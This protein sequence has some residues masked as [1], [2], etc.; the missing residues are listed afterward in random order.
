MFFTVDIKVE[1]PVK[2]GEIFNEIL[3]S[4]E[5]N[6]VKIDGKILERLDIHDLL[7]I[8]KEIEL[9]PKTGN[10]IEVYRQKKEIRKENGQ[11][12]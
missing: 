4:A 7:A 10:I 11:S 12:N 9:D 8:E 2:A 6:K 1:D 5:N 3:R